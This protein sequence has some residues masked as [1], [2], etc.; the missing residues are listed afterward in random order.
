MTDQ[1]DPLA[2]QY[3]QH[4]RHYPAPDK[5]RRYVL[6]KNSHHARKVSSPLPL[7]QWQLAAAAVVAIIAFI[8]IWGTSITL[9]TPPGTVVDVAMVQY[10]GFDTSTGKQPDFSA[11]KV[12]EFTAYQQRQLIVSSRYQQPATVLT[13]GDTLVLSN[14]NEDIIALSDSLVATLHEKKSIPDTL[15]PGDI[16]DIAFNQDGYI[17]ELTK[18]IPAIADNNLAS[19]S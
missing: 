18:P 15:S 7:R 13:V 4:K 19:C 3:Q 5:L 1:H 14:C 9:V 12:R 2:K 11:Q 8:G 16:V 10:H 17:I 6:Q